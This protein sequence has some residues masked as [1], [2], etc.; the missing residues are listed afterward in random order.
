MSTKI[1]CVI[2]GP[3][4]LPV[5]ETRSCAVIVQ[6][7][8]TMSPF[9]MT[10]TFPESFN[11]TLNEG[12]CIK[13]PES[14]K[15]AFIVDLNDMHEAALFDI[16]PTSYD[17]N[18]TY[19]ITA[20]ADHEEPITIISNQ[21]VQQN[22]SVHINESLT[23]KVKPT[24]LTVPYYSR[25]PMTTSELDR[26]GNSK[27]Y[28]VSTLYTL[29]LVGQNATYNKADDSFDYNFRLGVFN[30]YLPETYTEEYLLSNAVWSDSVSAAGVTEELTVDFD[31]SED[32]PVI[33]LITGDYV[34][35]GVL[36]G[37][38]LTS[39][40]YTFPCVKEIT[41]ED[42]YAEEP[43]IFFDYPIQ[44]LITDEGSDKDVAAYTNLN[45]VRC[46]NMEPS[47]E[48]SNIDNLVVQGVSCTFDVHSS[49]NCSLILN[50]LHNT[51]EGSRSVSLTAGD[52][53]ITVGDSFDL[54]GLD[55]NELTLADLEDV[56]LEIIASNP[57]DTLCQLI[58]R[59]VKLTYHYIQPPEQVVQ[60][61]VNGIDLGYFNLFIQN[62]HVPGGTNN[63][64]KYLEVEGTDSNIVYRSNIQ[65]K[66]ISMDVFIMGCDIIETSNYLE[67]FARLLA[68]KRDKFDKPILN[69]IEFSQYPDEVWEFICEDALDLKAEFTE[70]EGTVK[71]VVPSGTS[72][73][74]LP[75]VTSSTGINQGIAKVNPLILV[76]ATDTSITIKENKTNQEWMLIDSTLQKGDMLLLD[77][78][79]RKVYKEVETT[80]IV[81]EE[82]DIINLGVNLTDKVDFNSDWFLLHDNYSFTC[83]GG[84]IQNISFY[85]RR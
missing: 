7:N 31:Y 26:L 61:W 62:V 20:V 67:R 24:D 49:S 43:G 45:P 83:E 10:I 66:E 57:Y 70:Y 46:Y 73:L 19:T 3:E 60:T 78:A 13:D 54:W 85:E 80:G 44:D 48:L 37:N 36:N 65:P 1:F 58:I 35:R 81:S 29:T 30:T 32:Y 9:S 18:E 59:N 41:E 33:I 76:V 21:S 50:L 34:E 42:Y 47:E 15:F 77:C 6:S 11:V 4:V 25:I 28:T 22:P 8:T 71:L 23:V 64:L 69:T 82:E 68:N 55:Y 75:T 72:K 79:N 39:I 74:K 40:D 16:T 84:M 17:R 63:E 56:E 12:N 52:N 2:S 14:N 38:S 5:G 27:T 51:A 53:T